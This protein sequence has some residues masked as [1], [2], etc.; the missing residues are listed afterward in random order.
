MTQR[1]LLPIGPI[2]YLVAG[3]AILGI[4]SG[5]A[6][7]IR[8]AGYEAAKLECQEAAAA[9][10]EAEAKQA[11]EAATG[12]ETKREKAKV[13]YR[14]ITEKVNVE[15]EKPVYRNVCFEPAG[16]QL[17][18]AALSGKIPDT[19]KPDPGVSDANRALGRER[20]DGAKKTD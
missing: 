8:E 4:L 10:R 20:G 9:Q 18:N 17:A 15:V 7:K 6:W 12:L 2:V 13:V 14:T 5:I 1:G 3:I 19:A 11:G 16:V